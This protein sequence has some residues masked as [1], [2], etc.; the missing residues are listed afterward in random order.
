MMEATAKVISRSAK[1]VP[2]NPDVPQRVEI[3]VQAGKLSVTK[4]LRYEK[5]RYVGR[6]YDYRKR[7]HRELAFP[8]CVLTGSLK[9]DVRLGRA[10]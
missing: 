5:G 3:V 9:E 7:T 6:A 2:G 1:W 8:I 4:H 10:A